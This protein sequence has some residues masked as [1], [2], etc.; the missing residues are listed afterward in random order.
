MRK[1]IKEYKFPGTDL[2]LEK[3]TNIII[4]SNY[5]HYD[6]EV[7]DEPEKFNPDRFHPDKRNERSPYSYLPF[8]EGPRNCIGIYI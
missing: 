7:Y 8:G 3:G 4:P 2:I 5:L 1:S 6:V